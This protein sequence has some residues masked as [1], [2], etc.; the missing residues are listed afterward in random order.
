[1]CRHASMPF[2]TIFTTERNNYA[3]NCYISTKE[4]RKKVPN[5][6]NFEDL[7][8]DFRKKSMVPIIFE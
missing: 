8:G 4:I 6:A 7:E 3:W 2:G 1:M 5:T